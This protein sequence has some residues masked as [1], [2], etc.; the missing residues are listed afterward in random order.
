MLFSTLS[1][2]IDRKDDVRVCVCV[3]VCVEQE[4]GKVE[5]IPLIYFLEQG[6]DRF[7]W[8]DK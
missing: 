1:I 8:Y 7:T 2:V 6:T 3:C 4:S 5:N